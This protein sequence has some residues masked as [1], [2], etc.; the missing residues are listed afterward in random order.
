MRIPLFLAALT[1]ACLAQAPSA[2]VLKQVLEKRL[3]SLVP[4]G[5]EERQ[6]LFQSV[7]AA[8]KNGAFHPFLVTALIRDYDAGYPPNRY[9]GET[10]VGKMDNL[11]FNLSRNESGAWM[12]D[13]RMTVID[14]R[15]CT[16]NPA[17]GVSSIPLATLSG[18]KAPDGQVAGAAPAAS[19]TS[20]LHMG[21]WGCYGTTSRLIAA[22]HLQS[23]GSYLDSDKKRAGRYIH[24]KASNTVAFQGGHMDGQTGRNIRGQRFDIS[25]TVSCEPWR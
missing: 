13:G 7:T 16:K 14:G 21:E 3:M 1:A 2:D 22:F 25:N 17:A 12:V 18:A 23:D 9:Y 8:P 15:T 19:G 5:M 11:K 20:E 10:C 6:V 24:A 4:T